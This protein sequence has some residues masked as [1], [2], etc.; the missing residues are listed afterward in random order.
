MSAGE[1][2]PSAVPDDAPGESMEDLFALPLS[3]LPKG[4]GQEILGTL[5]ACFSAKWRALLAG[6]EA[7]R[8]DYQADLSPMLGFPVAYVGD[9][10]EDVRHAPHLRAVERAVVGYYARLWHAR[11]RSSRPMPEDAYWGYVLS[12]GASEGLLYA[13][14]VARD[15][16]SGRSLVSEVDGGVPRQVWVQDE[17]PAGNPNAYTPVVLYSSE[18]HY[19]VAKAARMLAIPTFYEIGSQRY[20]R[21]NPLRPGR[22][23][24]EEAPCRGGDLGPGAVDVDALLTLVEFF[25]SRGHPILLNLNYCTAFKGAYDDVEGICARLRPVLAR[26]G[27]DRRPVRYGRDARGRP[28]TAQRRGCWVNVDGALGATYAPFLHTAISQGRV[29]ERDDAGTPVPLP[30]FDFAVPEV[31]SIVTSV[32]KRIGSPCPCGVLVTRRDLHMTPPGHPD[33]TS[34]GDTTFGGSRSA[35]APLVL[36]DFLA[37]R[38]EREQIDEVLVAREL[39]VEAERRLGALGAG[40]EVHRA[41]WSLAVWFRKPPQDVMD[42]CLLLS[43]RLNRGGV[44]EEY[45]CLNLAGHATRARVDRL[46]ERMARLTPPAPSPSPPPAP[47]TPSAPGSDGEVPGGPVR[48]LA[49]VPTDRRCL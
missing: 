22:P 37:G 29:L 35:L 10:F 32:H 41:P 4:R 26:H 34:V 38:S 23:W 16:L 45:A 15:Y 1:D 40:W 2:G 47:S 6:A 18:T 14:W 5:M 44:A 39:A 9:P 36:W 46:V 17:P 28:L 30:R 7:P 21:D 8:V 20:P 19:S 25:A 49:L 27:L 33:A 43:T 3:G 24:P 12:L 31:C 13:L 11:P 42:E 48:R